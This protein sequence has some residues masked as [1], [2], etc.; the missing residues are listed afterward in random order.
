MKQLKRMADVKIQ[1]EKEETRTERWIGKT[2]GP[3]SLEV[4]GAGREEVT[5][6]QQPKEVQI[7]LAQAV[8]FLTLA[9][10]LFSHVQ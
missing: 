3:V 9:G 6:D 4:I 8:K 10:L 5:G 7:S 2:T 1:K